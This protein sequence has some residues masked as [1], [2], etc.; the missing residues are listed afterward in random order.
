[1]KKLLYLFITG[2]GYLQINNNNILSYE[3]Q[4]K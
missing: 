4:I 3:I 2:I 1:M